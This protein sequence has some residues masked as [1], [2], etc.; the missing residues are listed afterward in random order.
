MHHHPRSEGVHR[1]FNIRVTRPPIGSISSGPHSKY[2]YP[3][4]PI[5][6]ASTMLTT[7]VRW[8]SYCRTRQVEA[9]LSHRETIRRRH[10]WRVEPFSNPIMR[11]SC[12][13]ISISTA[14]QLDP[15]LRVTRC[16]PGVRGEASTPLRLGAVG[17][18]NGK[19]VWGSVVGWRQKRA[20]ISADRS[21]ASQARPVVRALFSFSS[22][23]HQGP[24]SL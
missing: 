21:P 3:T 19:R 9:P 14:A 6:W 15:L 16:S 4:R 13:L 1:R 2:Q 8:L 11:I 12:R 18:R 23:D 20:N 7:R 5:E 22:P 24:P 10:R 17:P